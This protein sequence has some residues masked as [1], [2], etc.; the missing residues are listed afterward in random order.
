MIALP[1]LLVA[2]QTSSAP[3]SEPAA[4]PK[5]ELSIQVSS[6]EAPRPAARPP[7]LLPTSGQPAPGLSL[8]PVE[9]GK[10][11]TLADYLDPSGESEPKGFVL[12]F[13][14]SWCTYCTQS[15]PTLAELEKANPS[16][17]IVTVTVDTTPD[18]QKA[19]QDKVRAAGLTG[20]VLVADQT[21]IDTW[22]GGGKSVPKYYFVDHN[23]VLVSKDEGFGDKVRP[24]MPRQ[25]VG[26]L[27][28]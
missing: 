10:A 2:C 14:A 9:G 4:T 21:A 6:E 13:M 3:A 18:K 16:L 20:P 15:L 7:S 17:E 11:W 25:V 12:A 28:D 22:V 1:L 23:G 5:K 24:L 8:A 19:E 26:A 27:R